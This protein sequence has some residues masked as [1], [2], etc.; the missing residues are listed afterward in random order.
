MFYDDRKIKRIIKIYINRSC[1]ICRVILNA[2]ELVGITSTIRG[3][4]RQYYCL[5]CFEIM[6][7]NN[8]DN[9]H[10]SK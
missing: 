8:G 6:R 7:G 10:R 2:H 3:T 4:K 1:S 9:D 5:S